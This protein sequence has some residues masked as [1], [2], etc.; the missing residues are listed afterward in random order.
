MHDALYKHSFIFMFANGMEWK[1]NGGKWEEMGE[2]VAALTGFRWATMLDN[3]EPICVSDV[4]VSL[5]V[6]GL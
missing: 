4:V 5:W 6:A 3:G 1:W 2:I